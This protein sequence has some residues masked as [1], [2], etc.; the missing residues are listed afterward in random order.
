MEPTEND[1]D[2]V[3]ENRKQLNE[4]VI[5]YAEL[6]V[7]IDDLQYMIS[8]RGAIMSSNNRPTTKWICYIR[9]TKNTSD[10]RNQR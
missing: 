9:E 7:L 8:K 5:A 4:G 3:I 1:V 10:E 6:V 2:A